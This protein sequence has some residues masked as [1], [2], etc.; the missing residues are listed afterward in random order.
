MIRIIP[1]Q[2]TN[3][4]RALI[5]SLLF[6]AFVLRSAGATPRPNERTA[7]EIY[8]TA[9]DGTPLHWNTY[10]PAGTGPWPAVLVIHG[11]CFEGGSPNGPDLKG[12]AQDLAAAG[13]IAF[14]IEYR[15]A[16]T[17]RLPGQVSLGRFPDQSD[18]VKLAVRAARLDARCNGKVGVVGGSAG[19]YFAAFTAGTGAFGADRIDVGV[20]LSGAYD[21]S[22]FSPDPGID[23]FIDSVTNYVGVTIENVDALRAASPAY[24]ADADTAPLFMVRTAEDSMPYSQ[25]GDMT[26]K[27]DALGVSNYETLTLPGSQHSFDYWDTVKDRAILF[28]ASW[29]AGNPPPPLPT[30]TPDPSPSPSPPLRRPQGCSSTSRLAH[31]WTQ[32]PRSRLEALLSR[33]TSPRKWRCARSGRRWWVWPMCYPIQFWNCTISPGT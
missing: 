29:F 13:F 15:L 14:A 22:D 17:G 8:A 5:F 10:T 1:V 18:D 21:L 19:G 2:A 24:L 9:S 12:C 23:A 4:Q 7:S 32:A 3:T 30:P 11:G 31:A 25:L 26:T 20:S 6:C 27:L 16:P 28:L 33:A